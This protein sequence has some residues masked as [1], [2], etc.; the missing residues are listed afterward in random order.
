MRAGWRGQGA[1][2]VAEQEA[3]YSHTPLLGKAFGRESSKWS[4]P[5]NSELPPDSFLP[6]SWTS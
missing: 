2:M 4:R 6:Q 5:L 3:E 1:I